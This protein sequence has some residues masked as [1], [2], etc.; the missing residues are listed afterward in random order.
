VTAA[1]PAQSRTPQ[2]LF[3]QI[4]DLLGAVLEPA[5]LTAVLNQVEAFGEAQYD[6]GR[7]DGTPV[8]DC[9]SMPRREFDLTGG[10]R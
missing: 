5:A 10:A 6:K 4:D 2:D 1:F 3:R 7:E 9:P 8:Y